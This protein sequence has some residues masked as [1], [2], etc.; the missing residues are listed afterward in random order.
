MF[1]LH[2]MKKLL[3]LAL[4]LGCLLS[5][6]QEPALQAGQTGIPTTRALVVGIADYANDNITDLR[7]ADRDAQVFYDYLRTTAGGGVAEENIILLTNKK[8]TQAAIL[9]G[10][11]WLLLFSQP[12]DQVVIYF[13]GHGD[14]EKQTLWQ[15]GYLL[16]YDT[17][18]NN[19]PNNAIELEYLN[20]VV[21][22]LSVGTKAK[23][24]VILDACRSGKLAGAENLGPSLTAEQA[25]VQ[26]ANEV[27]ILSCQSDQNSL[28]SEAW[29]GGRGLFSYFFINGLKG[30]ADEDPDRQ[31]VFYEMNNY[32]RRS[33]R[34]SL[35]DL[36]IDKSQSAVFVGHDEN[37]PLARVDAEALNMTLKEISSQAS[38]A[39]ATAGRPKGDEIASKSPE[40]TALLPLDA[41]SFLLE[42]R[43]AEGHSYF[44]EADG[45]AAG[46]GAFVQDFTSPEV[47]RQLEPAVR[48]GIM[49]FLELA[50]LAATDEKRMATLKKDLASRL[51]DLAQHAINLYLDGDAGELARRFFKNQA[52]VY[53]QYPLLL[54]TAIQ[55]LPAGH[56]LQQKLLLKYHYF[57]GVCIRMKGQLSDNPLSGVEQALEQQQIALSLDSTAAYIHNELG[58]LYLAKNELPRALAHFL[59]AVSQA[60]AWAIAHS[61]LC[62]AYSELGQLDQARKFA[63]KAIA[64]QPDYFGTYI[65][66]GRIAEQEHDYLAA[67]TLY[68]KARAL[69]DEHYFSFERRAYLLLE[70]CRYDEAEHQFKEAEARKAGALL[71]ITNLP[72]I[73]PLKFFLDITFE[74]P[75]LS[76]P[77]V[78]SK[79]PKEAQEFFLTGK[80][81]FEQQ[82][83]DLAA[84]FFKKTM[85]MKPDHPEVYY[86]LGQILY[87][88]KDFEA[89]EIY[90]QRLIEL[91][92]EVVFMPFYLAEVYR[93]WSRPADEEVIYRRFLEDKS[94]KDSV[95]IAALERLVPLLDKQG[96]YG[97]E[98]I[99][100][101]LLYQRDAD[102]ALLPLRL[103]YQKMSSRYPASPDWLFKRAEFEYNFSETELEKIEKVALFEKVIAIDTAF[104]ARAYIHHKAGQFYLSSGLRAAKE[105][106]ESQWEHDHAQAIRHFEQAL[107]R[108]PGWPEP[109]YGLA[110]AY[111]D[112]FDYK[113]A[114]PVLERLY[115]NRQI[116][117]ENR[118]RLADLYT[119]SG[120]FAGADTLLQAARLMQ[121][122]PVSRLPGLAG[123]WYLLQGQTAKAIAQFQLETSIDKTKNYKDEHYTLARLFAR[124]GKKK[125][126]LQQLRVA[127]GK[128]FNHKLVLRYDTDWDAMR[129]DGDFVE[130]VSRMK[131]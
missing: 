77:G 21:T 8:A 36:K 50:D 46:I 115:H 72:F 83:Y 70:T 57:N 28:E 52:H 64:L 17:P 39:S 30:L 110:A 71:L 109:Q 129:R 78:I 23:V 9:D 84:P 37:F 87:Q 10:L 68:R 128:G 25:A 7:F 38:N 130:L 24:V 11:Y 105:E 108:L 112:L 117:F 4:L 19:Y 81:Y 102:R 86:Y 126:A 99:T 91:R 122:E 31:V 92:P 65:N 20:K 123:K 47:Q 118:L 3:P 98:E 22:T 13:S 27:R 74:Y 26:K 53:T 66:L 125:E 16:A 55:Y 79:N 48:E 114:L 62:A 44:P 111:L 6:A 90:F 127:L 51:H 54:R 85:K 121:P 116:N 59:K 89:A 34:Q 41:F 32:L 75:S 40:K 131:D 61:N 2:T 5:N 104:S 124:E 58:V 76:G 56:P 80:Y 100:L 42:K 14:V 120:R 49:A 67:E 43:L 103:F 95:A 60:P 113:K 18:Y 35:K 29:G 12:G 101:W 97:D 93:D 119:R 69:N 107:E 15:L 63:E 88:Q 1:Y 45:D 94:S 33:M 82:Q 73:A 96:R 106:S